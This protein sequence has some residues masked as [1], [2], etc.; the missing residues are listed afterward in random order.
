MNTRGEDGNV[1]ANHVVLEEETTPIQDANIKARGNSYQDAGNH[2]SIV[3][4]P[5]TLAKPKVKT[6]AEIIAEY[7]RSQEQV[8]K[9][10][11]VLDEE[12][13]IKEYLANKEA[14]ELQLLTDEANSAE[15]ERLEAEEE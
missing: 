8:A 10:P 2:T 7:E 11:E 13:V 4:G 15:A 6:R 1:V 12:A 9:E 14:M 5:S 3:M